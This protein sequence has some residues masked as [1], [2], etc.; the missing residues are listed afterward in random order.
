MVNTALIQTDN[1]ITKDCD[2]IRELDNNYTL[3]PYSPEVL[4][5]RGKYGFNFLPQS[6]LPREETGINSLVNI[7]IDIFMHYDLEADDEFAIAWTKFMVKA[8]AVLNALYD[9]T[10]YPVG[11]STVTI[12]MSF[13][14]PIIEKERI[15]DLTYNCEYKIF[16][17]R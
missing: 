8:E 15:I 5:Q 17:T 7:N 9:K 4:I 11:V 3:T 12:G 10:N 1:I 16:A 6:I 2:V 13:D 14:N